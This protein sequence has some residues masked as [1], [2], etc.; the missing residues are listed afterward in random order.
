MGSKPKSPTREPSS[1]LGASRKGMAL[2]CTMLATPLA[3]VCIIYVRQID[4]SSQSVSDIPCRIGRTILGAGATKAEA[5]PTAR[6]ERMAVTFIF[7]W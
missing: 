4:Q 6:R 2:D 5:Q 1:F 3:R 7:G